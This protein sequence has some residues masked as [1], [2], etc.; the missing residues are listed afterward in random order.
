MCFL[1]VCLFLLILCLYFFLGTRIGFA[2]SD[3]VVEE[4]VGVVSV[5]VS[6]LYGELDGNATFRLMTV[7]GTAVGMEHCLHACTI[8]TI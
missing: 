2:H 5:L 6:V 4:S 1:F 3:Y 8:I 7:N